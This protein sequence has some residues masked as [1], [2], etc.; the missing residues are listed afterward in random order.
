MPNRKNGGAV[1]HEFS[2]CIG[3][4]IGVSRKRDGLDSFG[5]GPGQLMRA[6]GT[7]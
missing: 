6:C 5:D 2:D 4:R 1:E 7:I 3:R